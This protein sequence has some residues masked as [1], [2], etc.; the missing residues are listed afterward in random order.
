MIT[1]TSVKPGVGSQ[2][3][4]D[5]VPLHDGGDGVLHGSLL[6]EIIAWRKLLMHAHRS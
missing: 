1:K 3:M 6:V 2:Q 5:A 4:G